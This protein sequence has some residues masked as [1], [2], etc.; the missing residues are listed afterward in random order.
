M[1]IGMHFLVHGGVH[2]VG[3]ACQLGQLA[4]CIV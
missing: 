4:A 1:Q 2:G 3:F